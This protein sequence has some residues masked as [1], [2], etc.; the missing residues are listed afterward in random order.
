MRRDGDDKR[1]ERLTTR[2]A[3]GDSLAE[4][5]LVSRCSPSVRRLLLRV[6]SNRDLSDDLHQDT[7]LVLLR[8]F[9]EGVDLDDE[10]LPHYARTTALYLLA[11]HRRKMLRY[12]SEGLSDSEPPLDPRPSAL[13][14]VLDREQRRIVRQALGRLSSKRDRVLLY[15]VYLAEEDREVVCAELRL[16][17]EHLK[18]VLFRARERLRALLLPGPSRYR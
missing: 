7:F 12:V 5:E 13:A 9:R 18:R 14:S 3:R 10:A 11:N 1:F 17:S 6:T 15:R 16:K 2:I 4:C 8:R